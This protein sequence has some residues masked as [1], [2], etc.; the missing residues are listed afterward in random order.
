MI[1]LFLLGCI[2]AVGWCV[3]LLRWPFRSCRRCNG[4]GSNSGSNSKRWGSCRKCGGSKQVRRLGAT[5]VHRFWW[6]VLGAAL[7]RKR[8]ERL[9]KARD[10][11]GYPEM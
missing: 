1:V 2:F 6:S 10:K 11:A 7:H 3:S 9:D 8:K 5:A 4:S